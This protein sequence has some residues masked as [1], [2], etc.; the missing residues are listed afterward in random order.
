MN[1]VI[2]NKSEVLVSSKYP[3]DVLGNPEKEWVSSFTSQGDCIVKKCGKFGVSNTEFESIPSEAVKKDGNLVLK[4]DTNSHALYFGEFQL[5]D[6]NGRI[7]IDVK[8]PT[9]LDHVKDHRHQVRAEHHAQWLPVGK[10]FIDPL[11]EF[12]HL[13]EEARRVVD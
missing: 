11:L 3:L 2:E 5:Y 4:G 13:L 8:T 9:I 7:F 6:L 1:T 10:Y 12:D